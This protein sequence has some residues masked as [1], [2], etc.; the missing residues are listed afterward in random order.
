[1]RALPP[2]HASADHPLG[3]LHRNTPLPLLHK[4][5]EPDD[6]HHENQQDHDGENIH[7]TGGHQPKGVA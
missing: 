3:I 6:H 7:F 5:D 1:M 4:D 2:I